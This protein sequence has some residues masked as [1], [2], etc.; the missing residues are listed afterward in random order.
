MKE[1]R[2]CTL[3]TRIGG[4][5]FRPPFPGHQSLLNDKTHDTQPFLNIQ[6]MT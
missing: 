4:L 6:G 2:L 5:F 3:G 1:H